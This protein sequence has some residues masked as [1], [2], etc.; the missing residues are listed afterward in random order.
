MWTATG[1]T[2]N[3]VCKNNVIKIKF[4]LNLHHTITIWPTPIFQL[5]GIALIV[6]NNDNSDDVLPSDKIPHYVDSI[7]V[8]IQGLNIFLNEKPHVR[9]FSEVLCGNTKKIYYN[10]ENLRERK[11]I[12]YVLYSKY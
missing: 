2:M 10:L 4:L 8:T 6:G 11:E 7:I 3:A 5:I 9:I 12:Y 1:R